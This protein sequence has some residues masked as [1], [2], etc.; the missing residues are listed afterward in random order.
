MTFNDR[1]CGA[2]TIDPR[3]LGDF[4]VWKSTGTPAYQLAV[5]V[6]DHDHEITDVVRGD[7]LLPST[8]RQILVYQALGWRP[9]RFTHV[10]LVVG[11]DG[12]RLAKRHGDTRLDSLRKAGIKPQA[13]IG[14]V[15]HS[16]G[17]LDR[18]E[19]IDC[20]DLLGRFSLGSIPPSPWVLTPNLLASIG[21][22]CQ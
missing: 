19:P 16:C 21:Y 5:V 12:R 11:P 2:V 4:A 13:L 20:R 18:A 3:S 9:P 17:W 6:D 7:D 22:Q 14:L 10:P 8:P 15:A 1:F